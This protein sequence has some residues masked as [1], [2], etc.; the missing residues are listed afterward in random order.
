MT[1]LV[2]LLACAPRQTAEPNLALAPAPTSPKAAS[3][4]TTDRLI[5]TPTEVADVRELLERGRRYLNE[6]RTADALAAFTQ[7]ARHDADGTWGQ[8]ALFEIA[9]AHEE[10]GDHRRAADAFEQVARRYPRRQYARE[11]LLRS[12][13]LVIY[14]EDWQRGGELARLYHERHATLAAREALVVYAARALAS[15]HEAQTS[16]VDAALDA[17]EVHIAHGRRII[18]RHRLDSA[19]IIPRD[20]AQLY[21]ALGELRRLRGERIRFDPLPADFADVFERRA[22][23]LLDAQ[24]AYSDTMRAHDARWTAMA[25]YRVG[26]LYQR[27]YEDVMSAPRPPGANTERRRRLFE[28]AVRLR[29]SVLLRKGLNMMEHTLRMAERTGERSSWVARAQ[30]ARSELQRALEREQ[31]AIDASNFSRAELET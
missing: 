22:Q 10:S 28:A 29:Y 7:V 31:A 9:R 12:I 19:G 11:A 2:T 14:L 21:F 26:E 27:L 4:V 15:L 30:A 20:L 13:R 17:A 18:E 8:A 5:V 3:T 23:L 25:G 16:G 6:G 1:A 24:R